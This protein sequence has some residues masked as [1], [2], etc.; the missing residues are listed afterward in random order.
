MIGRKS[1]STSEMGAAP[2]RTYTYHLE[3]REV[4]FWMQNLSVLVAILAAILVSALLIKAS[5]ADPVGALTALFRGAFGNTNAVIETLVQATPILF[6]G[7]AMVIAFRGKVWNIGGEGQFFAGAL[8]AAWVSMNFA[9]SL[10]VPLLILSIIASATLA[11]AIWAFVPGILKSRFGISEIV[12]TVMMNYIMT[13]IV[14]YLLSGPWQAEG[15]HFLQTP[16]FAETTFLP[17]FF[18]SRLHLGFL[19]GLLLVALTYLLLWKTPLGYEIRAVGENPVAA[20]YKG[21]KDSMIIVVVMLLSGAIAGMAGGLELTGLHHRL[22]LDIS[23][24]YG[25]TGI[26]IALLG[27]L[28]PLG[29]VPASIFFGAL[30]NGST[31]MQI[32]Y[33]VPVPLVFTIQGI[34][35]IFLLICDTLFRYRIRRIEND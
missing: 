13:S 21:I 29:V 3:K 14:S 31:S 5:G 19:I 27:R 16:R 12:V 17:T 10:P 1:A 33:D 11:G 28:N 23:S 7:L 18:Q 26:L 15:D 35:L 34:V 22:R 20:R 8:A 9:D 30:V 24:G 6:T 2:R 32:H 4:G 25:Y